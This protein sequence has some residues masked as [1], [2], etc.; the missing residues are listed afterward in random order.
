M[1]KFDSFIDGLSKSWQR[2]CLEI[3]PGANVYTIP[4]FTVLFANKTLEF[5][6]G[7]HSHEE[8]EFMMPLSENIISRCDDN[9]VILEKQKFMPFNSM[10]KHGVYTDTKI[11][12]VICITSEKAFLERV[13]AESFHEQKV[14]FENKCF[15]PNNSI[16]FLLGLFIEEGIA[17]RPG[18]QKMQLSLAYALLIDLIR[19]SGNNINSSVQFQAK[20][21]CLNKTG[22]NR[23]IDFI[24]EQSALG[25]SLNEAAAVAGMSPYHFI[26]LF[27][28]QTGK[29]PYEFY[30]A[31]KVEKAQKLLSNKDK[32]ITEIALITGFSSSSHFSTLFK[33]VT[34]MSPSEYRSRMC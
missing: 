33:R 1:S 21:A 13:L 12:K 10:Q 8:Y 15:E 30:V 14:L 28:I 17:K 9:K 31:V 34:G 23:A 32:T 18:Y 7:W 27:K 2:E 4:E 5:Y 16:H 3:T 24:R 20:T 22:L 25:F 29:T 26:R 11:N 19:C 6:A